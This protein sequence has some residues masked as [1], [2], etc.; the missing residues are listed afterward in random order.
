[1]A[2]EHDYKFKR[3]RW[4]AVRRQWAFDAKRDVDRLSDESLA[5]I[6]KIVQDAFLGRPPCMVECAKHDG[7][8]TFT[9]KQHVEPQVTWV[10]STYCDPSEGEPD[11]DKY[12]TDDF[13]YFVPSKVYGP[14]DNKEDQARVVALSF[15]VLPALID[16]VRRLRALVPPA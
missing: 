3:D 10:P 1:M 8:T 16:E 13:E 6:E 7:G 5:A 9:I 11:F 12:D 2:D 4:E 15:T 14:P